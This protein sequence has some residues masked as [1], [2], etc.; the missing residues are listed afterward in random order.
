MI[1]DNFAVI[2]PMANEEEDFSEFTGMLRH[3]LDDAEAAAP[4]VR[5]ALE[6]EGFSVAAAVPTDASME[7]VFIERIVEAGSPAAS[8]GG[9]GA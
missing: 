3:S 8:G 2:V 6:A 7:D 4:R 5:R 9:A 1:E